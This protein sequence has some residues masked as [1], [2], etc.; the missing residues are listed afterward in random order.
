M[1]IEFSSLKELYKR[2]IPA[3][4]AKL[5]ELKRNNM[6]YIKRED[7]WNYLKI[8]KW[9]NASNLLLY[10][11]VDDIIHTDNILIDLY[12]KEEMKKQSKTPILDSDR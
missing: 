12:V 7:I 10:E 3:L 2:L 8:N 4:D 6:G 1:D 9:V 5:S 11:M